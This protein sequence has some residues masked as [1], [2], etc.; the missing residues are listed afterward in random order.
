MLHNPVIIALDGMP[1]AKALTLAESLKGSVWGFK[2]NDLLLGEG[3]SVIKEFK[4]FGNVFADPKL[5][6][7]PN[8]VSNGV[9]R[10]VE[11]GADIITVHASGGTDMLKAAYSEAKQA[12]IFAVTVLT[13]FSDEGCK[14]VYRVGTAEQVIHLAECVV[15]AKGEGIVCSPKELSLLRKNESTKN[16]KFLTPGIR[17]SWYGTKDD[18]SRVT[19]PKEAVEMGSK[20]IVIGRPITHAENP[21]DAAKRVIAELKFI[22]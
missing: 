18:Q 6:D 20:Y 12:E 19:S 8:T 10:L 21:V 17:P 9:K 5:Y 11:A 1:K 16:L 3:V 22:P 14:E 15:N 2:L 13:S 4:K 7:I